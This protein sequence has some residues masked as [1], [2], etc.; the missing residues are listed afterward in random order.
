MRYAA[1]E[2][3]ICA[4][5]CW[6]AAVPLG[7]DVGKSDLLEI[8]ETNWANVWAL[9]VAFEHVNEGSLDGEEPLPHVDYVYRWRDGQYWSRMTRPD[10]IS[11][12]VSF[13]YALHEGRRYH[14]TRVGWVSSRDYGPGG[15]AWAYHMLR[16][17]WVG[18]NPTPDPLSDLSAM[19]SD[20]HSRLRSQYENVDGRL[21]AVLDLYQPR[22]EGVEGPDDLW[23]EDGERVV[24][25]VWLDIE[26]GVPLK[27]VRCDAAGGRI[28]ATVELKEYLQIDGAWLP[29]RIETDFAGGLY[30]VQAVL[31]DDDGQL[32]LSVN[33]TLGPDDC[34]V[35]FP[36]RTTV[37]N[38]DT[39]ELWI[40]AAPGG[41]LAET[42]RNIAVVVDS[43]RLERARGGATSSRNVW[44]W[45]TVAFV[46]FAS[47]C[48]FGYIRR[49][50]A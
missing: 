31:H 41:T 25:T 50:S 5:V 9:E 11:D 32:R 18:T 4:L 1:T 29:T 43:T 28:S 38:E 8:W 42:M 13:D 30:A 12:E 23:G 49:R 40:S 19:L 34:T 10:E 47:G 3:L 21:A 27:W 37:I 45:S 46:G 17:P 35:Q 22:P 24:T 48:V 44:Y 26:R 15:A 16:P 36:N 14:S 6:V 7:A 39:G 33:P 20:E 2:I